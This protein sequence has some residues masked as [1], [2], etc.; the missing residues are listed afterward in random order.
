MNKRAALRSSAGRARSAAVASVL[1]VVASVSV[2]AGAPPAAAA[3][4]VPA[5]G[6]GLDWGLLEALRD[7]TTGSIALSGGATRNAD[8]T[9]H[10]PV[11]TGTSY[12]QGTG[13]LTATFG[14]A[15]HLTG[16]GGLLDVHLSGLA[17][18]ADAEGGELRADIVSTPMPTVED[19]EPEPV[20]DA[21]VVL[22]DLGPFP[23]TTANPAV[24]AGVAA[25]LAAEAAPAFAAFYDEGQVL[26]PAT[27]TLRLADGSA[28]AIGLTWAV[29]GQVQTSS[30][31]NGAHQNQAPALKVPGATNQENVFVFPQAR[32]VRHSPATGAL[33]ATFPGDLTFGNV[34]QGGYRIRMAD[35]SVEVDADGSG[36]V[37]A[38]VTYGLCFQE[39]GTTPASNCPLVPTPGSP[40]PASNAPVFVP[41]VPQ[42]VVSTFTL[43]AEDVTD[44][45]SS[46][47]FTVTPDF[48]PRTDDDPIAAENGWRQFPQELLDALAPA[49][50]PLLGNFRETGGGPAGQPAKAPG[51]ITVS[52]AYPARSATER[53]VEQAYVNILDR[54]PDPDGLAFWVDRVAQVGPAAA[55]GEMLRL[56]EP[57]GQV[58]DAVYDQYLGRG[59]DPD[60]RAFWVGR[61][62]GGDP[63]ESLERSFVTSPE[64]TAG[65]STPDYVAYLY[66]TLLRRAAGPGEGTYWVDRLDGGTP[67][68]RVV[69]IFLRT[70]E[71]ARL[72]VVLTYA[73]ILD[74]TPDPG[75]L[76]HWTE[77]F[78][79][80]GGRLS[81]LAQ[82]VASDEYRTVLAPA[83][84]PEGPRLGIAFPPADP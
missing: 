83:L 16:Q 46:I 7:D 22:A 28:P 23:L 2:L 31:L 81:L 61:L 24:F 37:L 8:G 12:D 79:R 78:Q 64:A 66:A 55:V 18:T 21:D 57:A 53:F 10:F 52:I 41:V 48:I 6:G 65:T 56:D 1:A 67:R 73:A 72:R 36:R 26:D 5:N 58:V 84:A 42:V 68:T 17:I 63:V 80:G 25:T 30:S 32:G 45:G 50:P 3:P 70:T 35:P 33:R 76:T 71:A 82:L 13:V 60:G 39:D 29:S 40:P 15:V 44:T 51:P 74:R 14:G 62:K 9:F 20:T 75:G 38:D 19:P 4:L 11:A 59:A 49:V 43:D 34:G 47:T 69:D 27:V 54:L 77:R